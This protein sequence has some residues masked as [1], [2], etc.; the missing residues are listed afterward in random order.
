MHAQS[1]TA[2]IRLS[3]RPCNHRSKKQ[4]D[5][6]DT[7][8]PKSTIEENLRAMHQ[9]LKDNFLS[10][11]ATYEAKR[12]TF[13]IT[14]DAS[15]GEE[16][17]DEEK[18]QGLLCTASVIFENSLDDIAKITVECEDEKLATNVRDC[19]QNIAIASAPFAIN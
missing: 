2:S 11:E 14:I 4:R 8:D 19:L 7:T 6:G 5:Q 12:A 13:E 15:N 10:V 18:N 17:G 1:S 16:V 9:S 3:S